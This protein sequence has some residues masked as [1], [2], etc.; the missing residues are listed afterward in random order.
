MQYYPRWSQGFEFDVELLWRLWQ[1]GYRVIEVP[2]EWQNTVF[3]S[4]FVRSLSVNEDFK[5]SHFFK[6]PKKILSSQPSL[7]SKQR[8]PGN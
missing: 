6:S 2:I 4:L 3:Q 8:C 1:G 5:K 7:I